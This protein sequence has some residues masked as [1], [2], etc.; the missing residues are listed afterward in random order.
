MI[1]CSGARWANSPVFW[2]F[3]RL[4]KVKMMGFQLE[5]YEP[6]LLNFQTFIPQFII[7]TAKILPFYLPNKL[8]GKDLKKM[9]FFGVKS[10]KY[11][12]FLVVPLKTDCFNIHFGIVSYS[13]KKIWLP[14]PWKMHV[15]KYLPHFWVPYLLADLTHLLVKE[16]VGS[17]T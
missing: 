11:V 5:I 10:R 12:L 16:G 9:H 6:T 8:E 2:S 14:F 17:K 15:R 7:V 4:I 13:L 1:L 3:R